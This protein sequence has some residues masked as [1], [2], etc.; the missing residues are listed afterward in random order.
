MDMKSSVEPYW[1]DGKNINYFLGTKGNFLQLKD[2][3]VED[4]HTGRTSYFF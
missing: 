3:L 1:W 4:C 2:N